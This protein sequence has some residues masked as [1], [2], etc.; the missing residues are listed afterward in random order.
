MAEVGEK[1][2]D[3]SLSQV[4][5]PEASRRTNWSGRE[6]P[7]PRVYQA[8][9]RH[10]PQGRPGLRGGIGRGCDIFKNVLKAQTALQPS[11][12]FGINFGIKD[13]D[14][15]AE[16]RL[17]F[18]FLG[19]TPGFLV[20]E[21]TVLNQSIKSLDVG[22]RDRSPQV[23]P[24]RSWHERGQDIDHA[25]PVLFLNPET[26]NEEKRFIDIKLPQR[27]TQIDRRAV[28]RGLGIDRHSAVLRVRLSGDVPFLGVAQRLV[29]VEKRITHPLLEDDAMPLHLARGGGLN[30]QHAGE[31]SGE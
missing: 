13:D 21:R 17:A 4:R 5:C 15:L 19:Q 29:S 2:H 25:L 23:A 16:R 9:I 28:F 1:S 30:D 8:R 20:P 12:G 27:V 24:S 11:L 18:H 10:A 3:H 6:L 14:G 22:P 31:Q 26:D 7:R